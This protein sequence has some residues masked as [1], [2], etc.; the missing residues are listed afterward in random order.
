MPITALPVPPS[1]DDPSS[2]DTRADAF[3]G[4][5]PTF[6]AEANALEENVNTKEAS[7][8]AAAATAAQDAGTAAAAAQAAIGVTGYF[9][10][11]ASSLSLSAGA[12]TVSGMGAA[13]LFVDGDRVTIMRRS[14]RN[15]RMRGVVG[16]ADMA[17]G[18]MTVTVDDVSGAG[19]PFTDWAIVL[20]D[21]EVLVPATGTEVRAM[22]S[23]YVAITPRAFAEALAPHALTDAATVTPSGDDGWDFTWTISGNR[24]LG[25]MTEAKV[26]QRGT[27]TITQD[28]TGSRV[29][30]VASAWK[31]MGGLGVLSTGAGK[32]DELLYEVKTVNEAGVATRI[33]YDIVRDPS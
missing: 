33:I 12:K 26:G 20:E 23:A 16:S 30:A 1:T 18:A 27:I 25:A 17:A 6:Q 14:D 9:A 5:L 13:K 31:R 15:A 28:G 21:L 8:V 3:L 10:S 24:T 2:F 19:G 22:S 32:I 29:L 4:A 11:S 7:A